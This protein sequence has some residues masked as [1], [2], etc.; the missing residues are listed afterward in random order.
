MTEKKTIHCYCDNSVEIEVPTEVDLAESEGTAIAIRE[1]RFLSVS[2]P[3]CG[4]LLKPEFPVRIID[5]SKGIEVFLVPELERGSFLL[6][7][8]T[9]AV[10]DPVRGRIVIGYPEL[11][12][13]LAIFEAG[14][15]DRAVEVI[16]YYLSQK[17]EE[18]ADFD[19][20]FRGREGGKLVFHILG[21]REDEVGVSSIA[22]TLYEKVAREL[23][24]KIHEEPFDF[25]LAPPY[26]SF[27]KVSRE[28]TV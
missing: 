13:K 23:P 19:I 18:D 2:C 22:F 8:S 15:D 24:E 28:E 4:K 25:L 21:L 26:V 6:G 7:R 16:K 12:E 17:V 5:S 10:N 11:V 20:H 27:K 1:G 9:Y 14:L 3:K